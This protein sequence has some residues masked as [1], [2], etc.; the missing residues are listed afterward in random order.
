M[1]TRAAVLHVA[2]EPLQI[3]ELELD[4]P[5]AG[6][7]LVRLVATSLCHT[8]L[9]PM[10]GHIPVPLP[11]VLGH[12]GAGIVEEVGAGVDSVAP[13]DRIVLVG[14]PMCGK[15]RACLSGFPY[16]CETRFSRNFGGTMPDGT[17]RLRKGKLAVSHFFCQSSFSEY[18]VVPES[19]AV[20]VRH[21]V[22]LEK[23]CGF[24]CGIATGVGAVVNKANVRAG[25]SVAIFGCGGVGLSVVMGARLSGASSIIAVDLVDLKL[26]TA[27]ELGATH[28]INGKRENAV[29]RIKEITGG[30]ADYA[31][32]CVGTTQTYAQVIESIRPMGLAVVLGSPPVGS[33]VTL[34]PMLLLTERTVT[35]CLSGNVRAHVDVPRWIDLYVRGILPVDKLLGR[36]YSLTEI[37]QAVRDLA[38]GEVIKPVIVF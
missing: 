2:N 29:D 12:E 37:N 36:T 7:I 24:G 18:A 27:S 1:K 15:C 34:D 28:V 14:A 8:D 5:R 20:K 38:E 32:E 6:E 4:G 13:G 3:E 21:D 31:F 35:G 16:A 26:S 30:G 33:K 22:S 10:K 19:M 17:K 23:V 25:S 11:M 9:H